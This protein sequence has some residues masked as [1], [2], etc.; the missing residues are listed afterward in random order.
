MRILLCG[1]TGFIGSN[2]LRQLSLN[3]HYK[4]RA[5]GFHRKVDSNVDCEKVYG[6]LREPSFVQEVT[7]NIDVVLQFAAT[8][9]G[10]KDIVN[11]PSLH[12]TD[13]AIMN[14]YLLKYA[15]ENG[16]KKFVFPSC[17]VMYQSSE[18][19][20]KEIDF[21]PREKLFHSYFGVGN[22]KL[23]I[24]KMCQFFSSV[25][26]MSSVILRH[27]NVYGPF[28]KFDLEKS[29]FLGATVRKVIDAKPQGDIVVWGDGKT[30]RDLLY[31]DDMVS[32]VE[33]SIYLEVAS[34]IFNVGYGEAFEVNDVV[35]KLIEI[36]NKNLSIL[37]DTSQP[38]ISTRLAINSEKFSNAV[39]WK[40][41][42]SLEEGLRKTY[43][44]AMDNINKT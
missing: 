34:D 21:D 33:K 44:W 2:I 18:T 37:H 31:I 7:K 20:L 30:A 12:V 39:D 5:V 13:N 19:P 22:T 43:D 11:T 42:T 38:S 9:S 16:A 26:D 10:S 29:H 24:E 14:S 41:L 32:A 3:K 6:D 40:I 15:T 4:F 25:S 36:S 35:K 27:S 17:T 23:Y 1:S 8:T 28:D